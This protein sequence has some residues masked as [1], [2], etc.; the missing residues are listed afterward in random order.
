MMM[1][2]IMFALRAELARYV[3]QQV[4]ALIQEISAKHA[5]GSDLKAAHRKWPHS[6]KMDHLESKRHPFV[7]D[8]PQGYEWKNSDALLVFLTRQLIALEQRQVPVKATRAPGIH[9]RWR[10]YCPK[11]T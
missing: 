8:F 2:K 4:S 11:S 6:R 1:G 3:N 9:R 5:H 10:N 7:E